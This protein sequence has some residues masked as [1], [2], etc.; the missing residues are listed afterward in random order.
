MPSSYFSI[1]IRVEM[2]TR[3]ILSCQNPEI[4]YPDYKRYSESRDVR[5]RFKGDTWES[6]K[7]PSA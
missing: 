4:K 3:E 2:K 5:T 1:E 7:E 6:N